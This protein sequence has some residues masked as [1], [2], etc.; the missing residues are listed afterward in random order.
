MEDKAVFKGAKYL[1]LK[2][3]SN[4]RRKKHREQLKEFLSLN[5][6]INTVMIL[7]EQLKQIWRYKS[8]T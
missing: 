6:V 3:R 2:N 8:R 1:L 7:K 4:V 5:E